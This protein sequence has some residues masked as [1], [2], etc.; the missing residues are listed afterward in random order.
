MGHNP[1]GLLGK[2]RGLSIFLKEPASLVTREVTFHGN[3]N[4]Q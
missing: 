1:K 4:F 2:K 3:R